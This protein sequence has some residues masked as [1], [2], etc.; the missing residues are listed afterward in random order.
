MC[1]CV[2]YLVLTTASG[3]KIA[4][5][6][7]QDFVKEVEGSDGRRLAQLH[8]ST[9]EASGN[10]HRMLHFMLSMTSSAKLHQR[11]GLMDIA[12]LNYYR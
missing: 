5:K 10:R 6:Y 8:G 12:A 7:V 3:H 1:R 11:E 4:L 2:W 9:E